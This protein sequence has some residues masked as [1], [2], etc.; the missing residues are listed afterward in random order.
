MPV[1]KQL[2]EIL[3]CPKCKGDLEEKK[4]FLIC[5]SCKTA[6]PVLEGEIPDLLIEDSITYEQA[7]KQN[8][9]HNLKL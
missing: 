3:A 8:F 5:K 2:L 4:M 1:N 7:K 9:K 6:Y